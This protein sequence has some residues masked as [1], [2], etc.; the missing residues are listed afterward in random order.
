MI[1]S[2]TYIVEQLA[3]FFTFFYNMLYFY[4]FM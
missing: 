1:I 4:K 3:E 2:R